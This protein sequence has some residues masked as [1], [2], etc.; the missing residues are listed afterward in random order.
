ME[1]KLIKII[2][3]KAVCPSLFKQAQR[4][5]CFNILHIGISRSV[6]ER[7]SPFQTVEKDATSYFVFLTP[8]E[9]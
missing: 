3:Q 9:V 6:I 5:E 7:N 4:F 8:D 1:A 2:Y